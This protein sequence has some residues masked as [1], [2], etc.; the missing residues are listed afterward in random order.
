MCVHCSYYS[1]IGKQDGLRTKL[2]GLIFIRERYKT[3]C[4]EK[5]LGLLT[6]AYF[7]TDW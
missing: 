4:V 6:L 2:L 5:G 1:A 7:L 3:E